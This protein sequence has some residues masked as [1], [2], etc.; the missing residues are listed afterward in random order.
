MAIPVPSEHEIQCAFIDWVRLSH[1][2]YSGLEFG[3]AVPNGSARHPAVAAKL[4]AEGVRKGVIDWLCP[5]R[6]NGFNGLGLEFKAGKN[7]LT[8]EQR[9]FIDFLRAEGW[10]VEVCYSTEEAIEQVKR[11]FRAG[12]RPAGGGV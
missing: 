10:H 1:K 8:Q 2:R 6:R 3:F 4:K 9:E 11:Y 7:K 12:K 5:A